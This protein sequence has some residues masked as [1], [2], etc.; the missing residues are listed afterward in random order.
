MGDPRETIVFDQMPYNSSDNHWA[1]TTSMYQAECRDQQALGTVLR[2]LTVR[3]CFVADCAV[4]PAVW[5]GVPGEADDQTALLSGAHQEHQPLPWCCLVRATALGMLAW[6]R[7]GV[8]CCEGVVSLQRSSI[9]SWQCH[10]L[11]NLCLEGRTSQCSRGGYLC[12]H[13]HVEGL[14]QTPHGLHTP[15]HVLFACVYVLQ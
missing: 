11:S 4:R 10:P 9:S 8:R 15:F 12:S 7:T 13:T 2:V 3:G 6:F 1:A 14:K 5:E